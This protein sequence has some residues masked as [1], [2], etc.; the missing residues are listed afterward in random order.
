VPGSNRLTVR[1]EVTNRRDAPAGF[2]L[3]YHWNFGPP[4][5][6]EGARFVAPV[7][8]MCPRDARSAEGVANFDLY[9][10]P[11]PGFVEQVYYFRLAPG[12]DGRTVALL[13]N[14]AGDRGVALRFDVRQF[15][16]FTLWKGTQGLNEGYVTGL[17]PGVNHPNPRPIEEARGRVVTL[18]PGGSYVAETTLEVLD[19]AH[20]IAAVE[21]EVRAIQARAGAPRIHDRPVGPFV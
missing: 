11:T 12:D 3:L 13:R 6:E 21:A 5:L 4:Q 7:A 20:A 10:A 18:P 9:A 8:E 15:P 16:C 17:E 1:D 2:E 19:A 14:R